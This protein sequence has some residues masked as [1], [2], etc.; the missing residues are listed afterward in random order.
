MI[1]YLE[2]T[3]TKTSSFHEV[4]SCQ[5]SFSCLAAL[6]IGVALLNLIG[7][8]VKV[9]TDEIVYSHFFDPCFQAEWQLL[10]FAVKY[11]IE[12]I[13]GNQEKKHNLNTNLAKTVAPIQ[14]LPSIQY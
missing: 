4:I 3:E 10:Q 13:N 1:S 8:R 9:T 14:F 2:E 6:V 5:N 12:I 11:F 7:D